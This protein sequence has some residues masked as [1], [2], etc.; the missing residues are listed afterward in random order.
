MTG[1][2]GTLLLA[3]S[4]RHVP[5]A[6]KNFVLWRRLSNDTEA[7]TLW[8]QH[9]DA[10]EYR[11]LYPDIAQANVSPL[12]HFLLRGNAELRSPSAS[13]DIHYYLGHYPEVE[14]KGVNALLHFALFGQREGR[15]ISALQFEPPPDGT[16]SSLVPA[17][18]IFI[19]N[20]WR[21]DCPLV[22]VVIP[23]FNYGGLVEQAIRS[24]L[25]QTFE[26]FEIIVVEGG[27]TEPSSLENV[28]RV[29]ALA[30]PKTRFYYRGERHLVGDNRNFGIG[31]ARGRY[32]CCLDADDLLC[33]IYLEVA[34]FLAEYFGYDIVTPSVKNFGKS[35]YRWHGRNPNFPAILSE[36]RI[37]TSAIFRRSA[38]AH[39][40]GFR[41]WGLGREYV[42]EDW[43][44]WIRLL[45]HGF[46]AV[47][48]H[49]PLFL[50]RVHESSLTNGGT[51]DV[52]RQRKVLQEAN[53]GLRASANIAPAAR[54]SV[55][56][57]GKNLGPREN[58]R[59]AFLLAIPFITLGGAEKLF[60]TLAERIVARGQRVIVITSLTLPESMP[61]EVASFERITPHV[62]QLSKLFSTNEPR[63]AF[64]RYLMHRYSVS[65]LMLA[66]CELVYHLLPALKAEFPDLVVVDQLFN[67]SVHVPNNRQYADAIDT[68]VVPS[69]QLLT[70]LVEKHFA[71]PSSIKVI[72]HGLK[73]AQAR[74]KANS[75]PLCAAAEGK[76]IVSF[77]GR[78]SAEKAPD[79]FVDIANALRSRRDLF[80]VMTGDGPER[81]R[82]LA[83][84]RKHGLE[85]RFYTPG[86]VD[87]VVPLMQAT[88]VFVLPSRVDGMPLTVLEAQAL[89]KPVVASRVGSL[90][91]MIEDEVSGFLCDVADVSA[92][93]R[94]ILQLASD[95]DLRERM[96]LAAQ[97]IGLKKYSADGML[98]DYEQIIHNAHKDAER[99]TTARAQR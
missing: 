88:D 90:P 59:P 60:R 83:R 15:T 14:A 89:G 30:L 20:D 8:N 54:R 80:F 18:E 95:P 4:P 66:G 74:D 49:E 25:N 93:C 31:Q 11:N 24:V 82:V 7:L 3:L 58:E 84:I 52:S 68:T 86:F 53:S 63:H 91:E 41:D 69:E 76:V 79:L 19:N 35:D 23:C 57:P 81:Q 37:A 40:G 99:K 22:S 39:V 6:V 92:F 44:F 5:A 64:L 13:F 78:L 96:G 16:D 87:D 94:R 70:S 72:P 42:Y 75:N 1:R 32:V 97:E 71:I 55:L 33:P 56:N 50:Y 61:D 10:K 36:N 46:Q 26:D 85:E 38:W 9:F 28:R 77:F 27:S 17:P 73:S 29:E 43:D 51:F 67:D 65:T 34:V 21:P 12:V 48:I 98:D 2:F 45:G 47:S 62:Y